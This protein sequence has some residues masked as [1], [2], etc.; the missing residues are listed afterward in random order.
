MDNDDRKQN[1]HN[2]AADHAQVFAHHRED[3]VGV[4]AGEDRG[5]VPLFHAGE[6][7]GGEGQLALRGL[8][9]DAPAIRVDARI[10]R[11]DQALLLIVLEE[12]VPEKRNRRGHCRAAQRE[13]VQPHAEQEEHAQEDEHDN[14]GASQVGGDHDDE[15]E[16]DHEMAHHLHDGEEAVD[17]RMLFDIR[18]L[19]GGDD[20]IDDL[21]NL[22]RLDADTGEANPRLVAGAV[23]LAEDHQ[24]DQ[25]QHVDHTEKF[26]L[27][28]ENVRV[29]DREHDKGPDAKEHGEDLHRNILGRGGHVPAAVNHADDRLVNHQDAEDRANGA[30][31]QQKDIRPLEK[32][33]DIRLERFDVQHRLS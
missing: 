22:G 3:E 29:N 10:V 16:N 30:H 9:G 21:D 13:P 6:T 17:I 31:D 28:A 5:A 33:S 18:H 1:D 12:I 15:A 26:P 7:A 19:P 23:V 25:Q 20:D 14:R 24:R 4:L 11:G 8:P 2:D 27:G 32:L